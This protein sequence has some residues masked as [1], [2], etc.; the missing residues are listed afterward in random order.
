MQTEIVG[1]VELEIAEERLTRYLEMA[2]GRKIKVIT[3]IVK[4]EQ[5]Y[6]D[7]DWLAEQYTVKDMSMQEIADI[8]DVSAMTINLWLN[9]YDIPTRS[10]G[11]R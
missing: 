2:D 10:R 9:K 1:N 3:Q 8:C 5:Q 6:R 11:R 4:S 7:R